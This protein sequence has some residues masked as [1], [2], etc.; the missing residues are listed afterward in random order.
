[1]RLLPN[2][3][4]CR[5]PKDQAVRQE[6]H[7]PKKSDHSLSLHVFSE[8]DTRNIENV[9]NCNL[10][11]AAL[12]QIR[13]SGLPID[14]GDS[15]ANASLNREE[16]DS[17]SQATGLRNSAKE[18][19]KPVWKFHAGFGLSLVENTLSVSV[20]SRGDGSPSVA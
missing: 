14:C 19:P 2:R 9:K 11:F 1:V 16:P 3:K 5:D 12:T 13:E 7:P 18:C 6:P 10:L 4:V 20:A 15:D 8:F 17:E